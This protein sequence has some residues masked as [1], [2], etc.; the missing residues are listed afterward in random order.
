MRCNAR[1]GRRGKTKQ[2][3]SVFELA[4]RLPLLSFLFSG[5][6]GVISRPRPT[7]EFQYSAQ[8][9]QNGQQPDKAC[10]KAAFGEEIG[11]DAAGI[12]R[13]ALECK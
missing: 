13:G 9:G 1:R 8:N 6:H 4:S 5:A 3:G 11:R 2:N 12:V 7:T 10:F